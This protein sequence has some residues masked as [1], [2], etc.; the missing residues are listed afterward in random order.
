MFLPVATLNIGKKIDVGF[1]DMGA[2]GIMCAS[3]ELCES[4]GY[5]ADI[6][7]DDIHVSMKDLAPYVT[8]CGE[9]QERFCWI[10]PPSFTPTILK[11]FTSLYSPLLL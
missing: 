5:G 2:G 10:S 9:T 4:G 7:V 8:A 11:I 6:N 3:S 1:K